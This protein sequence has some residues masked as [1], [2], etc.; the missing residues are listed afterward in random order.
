VETDEYFVFGILFS[1]IFATSS[2]HAP[3]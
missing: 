1:W 3:H 2:E